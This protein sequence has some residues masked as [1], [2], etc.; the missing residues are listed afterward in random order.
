MKQILFGGIMLKII[1]NL[2]VSIK[3]SLFFFEEK[4]IT[5]LNQENTFCFKRHWQPIPLFYQLEN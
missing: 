4:Q 1:H 3:T 2:R 5:I